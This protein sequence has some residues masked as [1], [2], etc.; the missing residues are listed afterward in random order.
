V[1][2]S[3][4]RLVLIDAQGNSVAMPWTVHVANPSDIGLVQTD[5]GRVNQSHPCNCETNKF[6][7]AVTGLQNPTFIR[8][9]SH[10]LRRI[11]FARVTSI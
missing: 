11:A 4:G 5:P 1:V 8:N 3:A 6:A 9:F 10:F 2:S 7:G